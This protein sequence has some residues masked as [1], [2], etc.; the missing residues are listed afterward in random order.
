VPDSAS[1]PDWRV[2]LGRWQAM[3]AELVEARIVPFDRLRAHTG[4]EAVRPEPNT[5]NGIGERMWR[6]MWGKVVYS[7][8]KWSPMDG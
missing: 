2:A 8:G 4:S 5:P 3:S 6:A 7:G 1:V